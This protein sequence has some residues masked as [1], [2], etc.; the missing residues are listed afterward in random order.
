MLL[1]WDEASCDRE[2]FYSV[3]LDDSWD[4]KTPLFSDDGRSATQWTIDGLPVGQYFLKVTANTADGQSQ[5]AYETYS[6]EL[7][8]TLHG[9]LCFYVLQDGSIH[10]SWF[11]GGD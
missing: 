10:A 3:Q 7:K 9:V 6:T 1:S 5:I 2:V 4:F 8:T 11:D